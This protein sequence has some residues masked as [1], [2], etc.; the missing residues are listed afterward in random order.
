MRRITLALLAV[1]GLVAAAPVASAQIFNPW[2]LGSQPNPWVYQTVRPGQYYSGQF[3]GRLP[4]GTPVVNPWVRPTVYPVIPAP[5]FNYS[6]NYNYQSLWNPSL[7]P[8]YNLN[9]NSNFNYGFNN[10]DFRILPVE[11]EVGRL[12]PVNRDL[13]VNPVSGTVWK[14]SRG[15]ALTR[16]GAFYRIPG[17]G[18]LSPWGTYLPGSGVYVNPFTGTRYDPY[19]GTIVR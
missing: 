2:G 14:P 12:V 7:Y 5:F 4:N 18:S 16:E 19:T 8:A 10:G 6:V 1:A 9:Y 15:I 11:Q 3:L 13:A 17:T